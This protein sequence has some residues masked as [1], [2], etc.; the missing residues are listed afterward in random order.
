[1][2]WKVGVYWAKYTNREMRHIE[3]KNGVLTDESGK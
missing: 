1:L 3:L 2:Y